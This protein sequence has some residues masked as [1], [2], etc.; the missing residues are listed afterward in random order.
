MARDMT[1]RQFM[2]ALRRNGLKLELLWIWRRNPT[3]DQVNMGVGVI[4][5]GKTVRFRASLAYALK[6]FAQADTE[7]AKKRKT[8]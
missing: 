8:V 3:P 4:S 2:A 6:R 1:S 5:S 7:L